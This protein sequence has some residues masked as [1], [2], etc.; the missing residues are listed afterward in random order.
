MAGKNIGQLSS[1]EEYEQGTG[2]KGD[3]VKEKKN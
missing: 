1:G 2:K 3:S